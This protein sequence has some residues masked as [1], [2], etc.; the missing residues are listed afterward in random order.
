MI[1]TQLRR[2]DVEPTGNGMRASYGDV[3]AVGL[4]NLIL[5]FDG[6]N[7]ISEVNNGVIVTDVLGAHTANPISG[8]FS[9]EAMNAFKIEDGE[10]KHPI[11]KAMISG[12]IFQALGV[13]SAASAEKRKLGPF[14]LPKILIENLRVVG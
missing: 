6:L 12:N 11:K 3:P 2:D 14:V 1:Y 5:D 4:S 10:I 7:G 13:A 9:V 8:D